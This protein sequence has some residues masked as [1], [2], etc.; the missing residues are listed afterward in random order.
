MTEG[1]VVPK[2][3]GNISDTPLSWCVDEDR[4]GMRPL[5]AKLQDVLG[6]CVIPS[7]AMFGIFWGERFQM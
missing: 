5:K 6:G 7:F 1:T 2:F 4:H 3:D